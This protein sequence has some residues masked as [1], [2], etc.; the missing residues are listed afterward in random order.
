MKKNLFSILLG[1]GL[2]LVPIY[3]TQASL[4]LYYNFND[5]TLGTAAD[6]E[7]ITNGGTFGTA[8]I[9]DT[10]T[11][12]GNIT[13][14]VLSGVAGGFGGNALQ[15]TP[16]NDGL[17]ALD[18]AN[19]NTAFSAAAFSITPSTAYTAMAWVNFAN[20]NGDNM[21]FGGNANSS[22]VLHLGS[23]GGQML[24]GHWADDIG[25]DQGTNI[26]TDAGNWHHVAYQNDGAGGTQ[27][28]Y[29][30]GVLRATGGAGTSGQMSTALNV[31][32]GTAANS[33]SFNGQLDEVRIYDTAL[34]QTEIQAAMAVVPE[35]TSIALLAFGTGLMLRRRRATR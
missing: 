1:T 17:T 10:G 4:V 22:P 21:I 25:P 32:I 9:L 12:G 2:A 31:L 6:G 20:G 15:L 28:L 35:P 14:F 11:N 19:I 23:R 34:T 30:D 16:A 18:A 7:S 27:S 8:G 13:N 5:E 3:S 26:G 24:S 29:F 33:G